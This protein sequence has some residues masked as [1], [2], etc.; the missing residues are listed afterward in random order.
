MPAGKV[1]TNMEEMSIAPYHDLATLAQHKPLKPSLCCH[2]LCEES[3]CRHLVPKRAMSVPSTNR[4]KAALPSGSGAVGSASRCFL[5][6]PAAAPCEP[7]SSFF[8]PLPPPAAAL[9]SDLSMPP[10]PE[11]NTATQR[12]SEVELR[13]SDSSTT[14]CRKP[15]A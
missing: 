11:S 13:P 14:T 10:P 4:P 5:L 12:S 15:E 8:L 9:F 1:P 6:P 7:L 2:R 3:Q